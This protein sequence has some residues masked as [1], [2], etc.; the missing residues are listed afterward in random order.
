MKKSPFI[1]LFLYCSMLVSQSGADKVFFLRQDSL[2]RQYIFDRPDSIR[3]L[4]FEQL[5]FA[6]K[7]NNMKWVSVA[8]NNLGNSYYLAGDS[9]EAEKYYRLN[10]DAQLKSKDD[11]GLA[12]TYI[13]LGN[14][15]M[16]NLRY[17]EAK[18]LFFKSLAIR[19][20]M[21][22]EKGKASAYSNL[23]NLFDEQGDYPRALEFNF[24]SL[25]ISEQ[26][27]NKKGLSITYNNI[28]IIY[29][30][31]KRYQEALEY[32]F[33]SLA[34][35][36]ELNSEYDVATSYN[37]I[38]NIYAALGST[39]EGLEH[40]RKAMEIAVE[41][42][43]LYLIS[44]LENNI[45]SLYSRRK[46]YDKA[47]MYFIE[48]LKKK[49]ELDDKIGQ[50]EALV[51]LGDLYYKTGDHKKSIEFCSKGYEMAKEYKL[52]PSVEFGCQCLYRNYKKTGNNALALHFME[53]YKTISDSIENSE[54]KR[55]MMEKEFEYVYDKKMT[56]DSLK[57]EANKAVLNSRIE[58]ER[59]QKYSLYGGLIL[60]M[61]F[62]VFIFNRFRITRRQKREI[63][64]QKHVI[65]E[66]Q[67][68]IV[69]SINYAR[70]IQK[71]HLPNEK[72]IARKLGDLKKSSTSSY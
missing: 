27:G 50:V 55:F 62:A 26:I 17:E 52:L 32:N 39:N 5:D 10:L 4:I 70:R 57:N 30:R 61:I 16:Q 15:A 41:L 37:N 53:E 21:N 44:M 7:K 25:R 31:Q 6:R 69:D 1:I 49:T 67:K 38:G 24:K 64:I 12:R 40:F 20:K 68:E 48:S 63:E 19:G 56:A 36:K 47:E 45:G 72:Y 34:L 35:R 66:K 14:I 58:K 54:K 46:E 71:A 33:K 3:A 22:D 23:A 59:Y 60:V 43:D 2:I 51:N 18:E 65:E 9:K 13:N 11:D 29:K 42:D 28:A 8:Q